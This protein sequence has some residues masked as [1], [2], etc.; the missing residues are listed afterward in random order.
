MF[1]NISGN[2]L[3]IFERDWSKFDRENFI[4]DY[5]SVDWEVLLKIDEKN[6]GNSTKMYLDRINM[7]LDTYA[8]LKRINKYKLKFKSKP[9]ITL[10]LQKSISA[11]N[12]LLKN[13]I[14]K[15][16]PVLKEEFH[17]KYKIYR[18]L[19]STLTKKSKQAYY[20]KY[21]E[22]NWNNTKTIW[23]GIKS[24]INLKTATSHVRTV[25]SLDNGDAI[26][27]PYDIAN[28]F[29][30]YFASIAET[31]KKSIKYSHK[32]FSNKSSTTIFLQPTDK[33]EIT[34]IVSS[35]NS[36]KAS[37]PNSIP[38]RILFPLKNEISKQLADLFNT[39]FITGVF[40]SV[41]KTAKRSSG[42]D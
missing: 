22:R 32:H 41:L 31:T 17:T 24:L 33:E 4:L 20:E 29:N 18:N 36:N 13:F 39:S 8:P 23:K 6:V 38:Y 19:L 15:K 37:G 10:G 30:N 28:N 27:N 42:Y 1:G 11:K 2:K 9:W 7:L 16:D 3:K 34:N 21:F 26:T 12:K 14:N 5:F 40:P 25:L 35:L